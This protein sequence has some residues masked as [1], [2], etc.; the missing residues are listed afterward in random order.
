M[1]SEGQVWAIDHLYE[2]VQASAGSFEI[3]ELDE[4]REKDGPV[5]VTVSINCSRFPRVD[6]GMPFRARERLRLHI[7]STFPLSRPSAHFTHKRYAAFPHV[8]WGDSICLYQAPEVEWVPGQGIFGFMERVDEWLRAAAANELDPVGLPLHPPVAYAGSRFSVIPCMDAPKPE[9]PYWGGFVEVTRDGEVAAEL[10]RWIS[11]GEEMP[12]GRLASAILL[13]TTMP[14][15]Y[16]TTMIDLIK[17][18][19]AREVPLHLIHVIINLGALSTE[20]GK[21]AIFMLGAA[22]RGIA[23]GPAL[24]HLACWLIDAEQCKKLRDAVLTTTPNNPKDIAAFYDWAANAKVEW[25][26]VLEDRPEIVE[27]RDSQSSARFWKDKHVAILGCG[28]IGSTVAPMLARAGIGRLQLYDNGFVTPGVIVRQGF[29][30][31]H[32]GYTKSS[33]VRVGVLGARP[34]MEVAAHHEDVVS[35]LGDPEALACLM[36]ADAIIDATASSSVATALELHFRKTAKKHPPIVSMAIGHNADFGLMTL[37]RDTHTGMSLDADRRT[38]LDLAKSGCGN[39]Y[40]EEFWPTDAAR[41]KPFQPEPGCSSPT[42]RGSYA[43]V[44]SLAARMTNMAASWLASGASG[45]R[46]FTINLSGGGLATGPTRELEFAWRP[47]RVVKDGLQGYE[48]RMSH[49][50]TAAMLAWIRRS[51]RVRG[52]CVETGGVLFGEVDELLKVIWIDEVSGPPSDSVSSPESFLCGTSGIQEMNDEKTKRT[53]GSVS[54]LGMWHTHPLGMPVPSNTDLG[55]MEQLLGTD[56]T[57][58]GRRFLMIIVGGTTKSPIVSA[59][60]FQ[61]SDYVR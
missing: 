6:G 46:A 15:E 45:P 32:V 49:E 47:H 43:D 29:R 16:P 53:R 57:F 34:G 60:V 37:V 21:P 10:G 30:R 25:C 14:H 58:L 8:Q 59:S 36:N 19:V 40:F 33:A 61:R 18:L 55:A 3:V 50:A 28:A 31:D 2:I 56:P 52:T 22:M 26:R 39:A 20:D 9:P 41:R 5:S 38:K 17:A 27:R 1:K 44:L 13:P 35:I 51:E 54:F 48:I 7:P 4:A 42:F 11:Y 12:K 23:G 24:Q